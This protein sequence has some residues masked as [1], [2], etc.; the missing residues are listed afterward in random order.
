MILATEKLDVVVVLIKV[1]VQIAAAVGTFHTPGE[2]AGLLCN[3]SPSVARGMQA[4]HL[5]PC[6]TVNNRLMD[7]EKD[8][9]VFLRDFQCDVSFYR[10]LNSS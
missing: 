1:E 4:L 3:G 7:I 10:T 5:F 8:C 6:D 2:Y 9:P